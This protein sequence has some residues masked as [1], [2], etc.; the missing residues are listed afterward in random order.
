MNEKN[1]PRMQSSEKRSA[2]AETQPVHPNPSRVRRRSFLQRLGMAGATL[3]PASALLA[4]KGKAQADERK[5]KLS[6]GDVAILR[7]LAA[8]EIIE[9]D[10]WQQ[11]N[12]LGGIGATGSTSQPYITDLQV[13]DG[14]MPQYIADNT[15]DEMSHVAFLNAFLASKGEQPVNFD[16]FRNIPPS[17]VTAVPQTGR[18]TNLKQLS[19]DT[20]WWVRY[21]STTNPDLGAVFT[22]QAVQGLN[23]G[24]HPAIPV[25][26]ADLTSGNHLLAIAFTAGFH[27]GFIEQA[28]TSLYATLSQKVTS[29]EVLKITLS[30]G[31]SEVMHFQVWH[32]KAGNATPLTDDGI[33][34]VDLT[35]NQPET[36]QANLIMPEPCDFISTALP[37]CAIIRPTSPGQLDARGAINGFIADGLFI[38]QQRSKEFLD[39]IIDMAEQADAAR[40]ELEE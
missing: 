21:R 15:D 23:V 38:G 5:G 7:L 35:K 1:L 17:K 14:D 8:A 20:S 27:F 10:L 30:I 24:Q 3:L 28:G 6:K 25:T 4:T 9:T 32:D 22:K 40:R 39:L 19:V 12:E 36:L 31:G 13:L 34:F 29:A 16:A 37:Q 2:S 33:T 26:N 11:Y 18:L